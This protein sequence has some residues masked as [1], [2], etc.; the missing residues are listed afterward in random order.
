MPQSTPS[1]RISDQPGRTS[2]KSGQTGGPVPMTTP[3]RSALRYAAAMLAAACVSLS[4]ASAQTYII[5]AKAGKGGTIVPSGN[6]VVTAG[7]DQAFTITPDPGYDISS[8]TANK[9][10][11]G[12]VAS[13]T[14]TNVQAK[15]S[16]K[17]KFAVQTFSLSFSASG[18]VTIKPSGSAS[19]KYGSSAKITVT[20][21]PG[22]VGP[23][24]L[25]VDGS[26]VPLLPKGSNYTYTLT[27]TGPHVVVASP[28]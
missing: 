24:I 6:V 18:G 14:F 25:T 16:I 1:Q 17:V 22:A 4:A 8:V 23:P 15:G 13:Y 12:Q 21:N 11:V 28:A 9:V 2:G 20:P 7:A 3:G 10:N 19:Y 27:V 26:S 5:K